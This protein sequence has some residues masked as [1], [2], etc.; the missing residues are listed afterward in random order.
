MKL[1]KDNIAQSS[2]FRLQTKK[3]WCWQYLLTIG[4]IFFVQDQGLTQVVLS[5]DDFVT[6]ADG[7][8][9]TSISLT[10]DPGVAENRYM[11]VAVTTSRRN[12]FS[13]TFGGEPLDLLG[14]VVNGNSRVV[15]FTMADPPSG[16][17]LL[18]ATLESDD[19]G[20]V[21]GVATFSNVDF[22]NPMNAFT[23][24]TG[25]SLTPTVSNVP[26]APGSIV[27]SAVSHR[28]SRD[29]PLSHGPD[30]NALWT[31]RTADSNDRH[32]SAGSTKAIISGTTTSMTYSH[33]TR[34]TNWSIGAVSFN[35]LPEADLEV[36]IAV[37][38][39]L[40]FIGQTITFTVTASNNG[41][42]DA[43]DVV[44][45]SLLADGFT[46]V[47]HS[48]LFGEYN[49]LTGIWLIPELNATESATL[50]IEVV[51]NE[52]GPYTQ[53]VSI[54]S[55]FVQDPDLTNNQDEITLTIC[56]AGAQRPL[57]IID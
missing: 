50:E 5:S 52:T 7:I 19:R 31:F 9:A 18:E 2:F 12:V 34:S 54:D 26:T 48:T 38:N 40:P 25:S 15:F 22:N 41:P 23:P 35:P 42:G 47:G 21:L 16:P 46:Y 55:D 30:Q 36:A 43:T 39:E 28:D 14:N 3:R 51:V 13:A 44:V 45:Q 37:D 49:P 6:I 57:F 24:A 11:I 1:N 56:Q 17:A 29:H 8:T 20:F 4:L 33:P 32:N 10:H 53:T 27:F